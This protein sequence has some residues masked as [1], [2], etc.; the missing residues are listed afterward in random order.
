MF[1]VVAV[2]VVMVLDLW[3]LGDVHMNEVRIVG[4]FGGKV[5]ILG[6]NLG[7]PI[8]SQNLGV[9]YPLL[10]NERHSYGT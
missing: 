9:K 8:S 5:G 10:Q 7:Y 4:F 6:G 1:Y 2:A 3:F